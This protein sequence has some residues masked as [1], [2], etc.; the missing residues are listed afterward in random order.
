MPNEFKIV[1]LQDVPAIDPARKGKMDKLV[2]YEL[3][4]GRRRFLRLA[5]EGSSEQRIVEAVRRDL[6]ELKSI[7]G[8]TFPH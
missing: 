1:D 5:A 3:S 6:A 8:K 4:D 2:K 7:I